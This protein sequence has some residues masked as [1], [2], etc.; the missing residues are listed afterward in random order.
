ML[1]N[2]AADIAEQRDLAAQSPEKV[3]DLQALWNRWNHQ[4]VAPRWP[5][6]VGGKPV[7]PGV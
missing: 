7:R 4:L 1:F 6:T 2:L 5:A 3:R